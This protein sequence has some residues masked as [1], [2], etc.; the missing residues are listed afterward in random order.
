[1]VKE[2]ETWFLFGCFL[3]FKFCHLSF[4]RFWIAFH[5]VLRRFCNLL[6]LRKDIDFIRNMFQLH[7]HC[8]VQCAPNPAMLQSN[9]ETFLQSHSLCY[10]LT[11]SFFGSYCKLINWNFFFLKFLGFVFLLN[12]VRMKTFSSIIVCTIAE[13]QF[14]W[15]GVCLSFATKHRSRGYSSSHAQTNYV[16]GNQKQP[17]A[18]TIYSF[19]SGNNF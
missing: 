16:W 6:K 10:V 17:F 5:R 7:L 9:P 11:C 8:G 2:Q 3:L 12:Y 19:I 14:E 15:F 1:M 18:S 4:Y 13:C